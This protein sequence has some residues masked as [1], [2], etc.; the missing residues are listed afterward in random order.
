MP[1]SKRSGVLLHERNE[2]L[3]VWVSLVALL[4]TNAVA[5]GTSITAHMKAD[6]ETK[7]KTAYKELST[8]VAEVSKDNIQLH[9]DLSNLRGYLAGLA[10][11][12]AFTIPKPA[13]VAVGSGSGFGMGAGSVGRPALRPIAR[14]GSIHA[15]PAESSAPAA[16][17]EDAPPPPK[18]SAKPEQYQPKSVDSL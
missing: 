4:V 11:N 1:D 9:N 7:A 13:P 8:A 5:L 6:D 15:A 3:K 17:V 18:M 2:R 10:Q 12:G 14:N 16:K